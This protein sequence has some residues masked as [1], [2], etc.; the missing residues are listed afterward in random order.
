MQYKKSQETIEQK[1]QA[2]IA[3]A[4]K[5]SEVET[6]ISKLTDETTALEAI[7]ESIEK[8]IVT[9]LDE[10]K[11]TNDELKELRHRFKEISN[12]TER[13]KLQDEISS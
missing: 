4:N 7:S 10:E 9:Y 11:K 12:A 13:A 8:E 6:E 2:A 1:R 5:N 3:I